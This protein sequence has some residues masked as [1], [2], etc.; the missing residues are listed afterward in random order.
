MLIKI[1]AQNKKKF[2]CRDMSRLLN[3]SCGTGQCKLVMR[4]GW[5]LGTGTA[6]DRVKLSHSSGAE[7]I[8][9]AISYQV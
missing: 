8:N 9:A 1:E 3:L 4:T 6:V 7:M 5:L 2:V